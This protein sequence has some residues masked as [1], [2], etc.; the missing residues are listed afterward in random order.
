MKR[1]LGDTKARNTQLSGSIVKCSHAV[2]YH[3]N[4]TICG[5]T[6]QKMICKHTEREGKEVHRE[7]QNLLS[8]SYWV[9]EDS[10]KL[11]ML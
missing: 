10:L 3:T 6:M 1:Q 4:G 7:I 2:N 5:S 9:S 8:S 11:R